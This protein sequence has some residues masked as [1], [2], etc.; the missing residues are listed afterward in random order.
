MAAEYPRPVDDIRS[1][2]EQRF[3]HGSQV[4]G[5]VL[6]VCIVGTD[7]LP[8]GVLKRG[9][10]GRALAPVDLVGQGLDPGAGGCSIP[11]DLTGPVG[12]SVV[13]GDEFD[14][15]AEAAGLESVEGGGEGRPLVYTGMRTES[16]G[17]SLMKAF[18]FGSLA[19]VASRG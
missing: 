10:D 11:E 14:G 2:V 6:E 5:I 4:P 17:R 7:E 19:S 8:G 15:D 12:R 13:Q 3:E 1:A 18:G 16:M 9:P